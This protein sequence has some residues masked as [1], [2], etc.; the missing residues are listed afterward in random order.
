M[1]CRSA[2]DSV[3]PQPVSIA[4]GTPDVKYVSAAHAMDAEFEAAVVVDADTIVA[5]DA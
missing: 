5:G 4:D 1:Y 3:P 2:G